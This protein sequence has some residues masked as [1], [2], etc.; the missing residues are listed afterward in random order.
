VSSLRP[1][2]ELQAMTAEP[3]EV[4]IG[5]EKEAGERGPSARESDG[6][7]QLL[8]IQ[9]EMPV[10]NRGEWCAS[11]AG[12]CV[13]GSEGADSLAV[14]RIPLRPKGENSAQLRRS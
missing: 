11:S 5:T 13:A 7:T 9:L 4:P 10:E 2:N 1:Q 8:Y 14:S 12:M 3:T 6:R